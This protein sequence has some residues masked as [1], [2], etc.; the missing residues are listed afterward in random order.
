M[1]RPS[2]AYHSGYRSWPVP[3]SLAASSTVANASVW[4]HSSGQAVKFTEWTHGFCCNKRVLSTR[5]RTGWSCLLKHFISLS[6]HQNS[7]SRISTTIIILMEH[8]ISAES[9][10]LIH[11][12]ML[13]FFRIVVYQSSGPKQMHS[14]FN[15]DSSSFAVNWSFQFGS[16]KIKRS[17]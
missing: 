6:E 14:I 10:P 8:E 16:F 7:N 11:Q 1:Y 17:F 12:K 3:W 9:A 15:E 13:K 5:W 4:T 2:E